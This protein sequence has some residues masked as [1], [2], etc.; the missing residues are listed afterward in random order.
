MQTLSCFQLALRPNLQTILNNEALSNGLTDALLRL[1]V[2][3]VTVL[4]ATVLR[5]LLWQKHFGGRNYEALEIDHSDSL[6][7]RKF[8]GLELSA[9]GKDNSISVTNELRSFIDDLD[10]FTRIKIQYALPDIMDGEQNQIFPLNI[11]RI[12]DIHY[13][14]Q[15]FNANREFGCTQFESC[16]NQ[17]ALFRQHFV[18]IEQLARQLS[19]ALGNHPN[20]NL[21]RYS[22]E[23]SYVNEL[24][25]QLYQNIENTK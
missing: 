6:E 10:D 18:H 24:F 16:V 22:G 1:K 7:V 14:N 3:R 4:L 5:L 25:G 12:T 2:K 13:L 11:N 23:I 20:I 15:L 9:L 8:Y 17:H 21:K 19:T